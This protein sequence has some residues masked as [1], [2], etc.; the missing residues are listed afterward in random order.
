MELTA[1]LTVLTGSPEAWLAALG[2]TTL[3]VTVVL[4]LAA[5]IVI[6]LRR[7]A[8]NLRHLVWAVALGGALV[9]PVAAGML[10]D[11]VVPVPTLR[12]VGVQ[13][14]PPG[15]Q[16]SR[17]ATEASRSGPSL[18]PAEP[19]AALAGTVEEATG[20]APPEG[21]DNAGL[22]AA[23]STTPGWSV[24][25]LWVWG[26][27]VLVLL[28]RVAYGAGATRRL[29]RQAGTP[30]DGQ[31]EE[32]AS[33]LHQRLGLTRPVR[34]LSSH[35]TSVPM[36]WGWWR[37]IVLVPE[38]GVWSTERKRVVL[39][40]ELSHVRRHDCASQ[41]V[42]QLVC[43]LHWF[44]PLVWLGAGAL[45]LER[46]RACDDAVVQDGTP[47]SSYADHL[48]EIARLQQGRRWSPTAA[49]AMARP[50]QLEGRL[51]SILAPG[52]R[53]RSNRRTSAGLVA[54][55]LGIVVAMAAVTPT[56]EARVVT[57]PEAVRQTEVRLTPPAQAA[58]PVAP[59]ESQAA[60]QAP[61]APPPRVEVQPPDE[62]RGSAP[63]EV[64]RELAE[65]ARVQIER[66]AEL[67]EE[68]EQRIRRDVE[69]SELALRQAQQ[70]QRVIN[71]DL[72]VVIEDRVRLALQ[73]GGSTPL[74]PRVVDLLLESLGDDDPEVRERAV[75]GLGRNRVADA[76]E[77]LTPLLRDDDADVR[78]RTAWALGMLRAEV[79]IGPLAEALDDAE[80]EV[81]ARAAWA[82]GM[83]R[84]A[85]AVNGLAAALEHPDPDVVA[86]AAEALGR[87]RSPT[88]VDGLVAALRRAEGDVAAKIVEALGRVGGDRALEALIEVTG[89]ASPEIRRAVIEALSGRRWSSNRSP[90]PNPDPNPDPRD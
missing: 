6:A 78:E 37:P 43:A 33:R 22:A 75:W 72:Q 11:V 87:I 88:A 8:A 28:A 24:V 44:N 58:V 45:R 57:P 61:V 51:L 5:L 1:L 15:T 3:R 12:T 80:P 13:P 76:A 42:A 56:T 74:D 89:D 10:P 90:N 49:V 29:G 23:R 59:P 86:A 52:D 17:V 82:L 27:G 81:A 19:P 25:A 38:T 55:M 40:H 84:D 83:I 41:L 63:R 69:A 46:E 21:A 67:Q 62:E 65:L 14:A 68:I 71:R 54:A 66:A 60:A 34:I 9:L 50:S 2:D 53:P 20:V 85:A 4:L 36:T 70:A 18:A 73:E 16:T 32:L 31:W 26:V 79:G 7:S 47:A 30:V 39:L 48:L 35:A 64:E 77:P